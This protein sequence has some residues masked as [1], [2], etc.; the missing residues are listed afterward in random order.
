M[1]RDLT[2]SLVLTTYFLE[3]SLRNSTLFARLFFAERRAQ[4]GHKARFVQNQDC[5]LDS[6]F[7]QRLDNLSP[8]DVGINKAPFHLHNEDEP[9]HQ[10]YESV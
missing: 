10:G 8:A 4:A 3:I 2:I 7:G 5:W 9:G 1:L 6:G